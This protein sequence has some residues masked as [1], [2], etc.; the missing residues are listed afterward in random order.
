MY[1]TFGCTFAIDILLSANLG[2]VGTSSFELNLETA[3]GFFDVTMAIFEDESFTKVAN[4][5]YA[6]K[7]PDDIFMGVVAD[8]ASGFTLQLTS[9]WITPSSD[10]GDPIQYMIIENGCANPDV[11]INSVNFIFACQLCPYRLVVYFNICS[12]ICCYIIM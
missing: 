3:N 12:I 6:I 8:D 2:A 4:S 5:D 1:I 7:V 10:S 9:C 11:C